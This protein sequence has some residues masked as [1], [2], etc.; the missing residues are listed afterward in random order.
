MRKDQMTLVDL[1]VMVVDSQQPLVVTVPRAEVIDITLV[2]EEVEE[3]VPLILLL[4]LVEKVALV[5]VIE[6]VQ[7]LLDPQ[8]LVV[9]EEDHLEQDHL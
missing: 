2:V 3:E 5:M 4:V 1:E 7:V 6:Q 8:I 9:A